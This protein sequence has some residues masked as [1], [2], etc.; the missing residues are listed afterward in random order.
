MKKIFV[1]CFAI[2]L[3]IALS[4]CSKA[5]EVKPAALSITPYDLF[6]GDAKKFQY[7]VGPMAGAVKL[8]YKGSKK[9]IQASI[10]IWENGK[11]K[12]TVNSFQ[13]TLKP[14]EKD[15]DYEFDGEFIIGVKEKTDSASEG[16]S[17]Y[18][19]LSSFVNKEGTTSYGTEIDADFKTTSSMSMQLNKDE[20]LTIPEN[21][22]I[23]V[24]GMQATDQNMM[25]SS[26]LSMLD[27]VRWAMIVTLSLADE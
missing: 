9:S 7:F 12:E 3:S 20:E 17:K 19:V 26:D 14:N 23:A 5:I 1:L 13:G 27:T 22:E 16:N 10:A 11:K 6:E 4:G 21:E 25:K 8:K 24:W 18:I 15:G 2:I